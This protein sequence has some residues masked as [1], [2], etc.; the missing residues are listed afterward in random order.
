M[1]AAV[2]ANETV[3]VES[4]LLGALEIRCDT[5]IDFAGGVPGFP[6]LTRCVL[7]ETQRESFV[8]LQSVDEPGITLLLAD[9]FAL[10]PGFSLDVPAADMAALG[11]PATP[12]ALLVLTVVELSAGVPATA[13]LQSPIVINR[14]RGCGRQVVLPDSTYG[15]Q[16]RLT[17]G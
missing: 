6:Q 7:V 16:F 5:V 10:V 3:V 2:T 14:E 12:D 13:N 1:T 8:W 17:A 15:M 11:A 4:N 9:P